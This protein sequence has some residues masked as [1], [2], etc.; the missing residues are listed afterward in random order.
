[1]FPLIVLVVGVLAAPGAIGRV[2]DG[3]LKIRLADYN[4]GQGYRQVASNSGIFD[5]GNANYESVSGAPSSGIVGMAATPDNEGYWL[6]SSS[7]GVYTGGDANFYGSVTSPSYPIVGMAATPDAGGYWLVSSNGT[8]YGRGDAYTYGSASG[9]TIVG[10]AATADGGGYWLVTP[11]GQVFEFGDAAPYGSVSGSLAA[12]IV[13]MAVTPDGAG[14]WLVGADGGVFTFG[15]AGFFGSPSATSLPNPIVGIA[16]SP[17]G[18]GYWLSGS[19]GGVLQYGDAQY[20]GGASSLVSSGVVG[21]VVPP[22]EHAVPPPAQVTFDSSGYV[23]DYGSGYTGNTGLTM[24]S[25]TSPSTTVTTAGCC[26]VAYVDTSGD[27]AIAGPNGRTPTWVWGSNPA[28]ARASPRS[29]PAATKWPSRPLALTTSTTTEPPTQGAP[30][31]RRW[32]AP[33]R[34]RPRHRLVA[35]K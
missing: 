13:G 24:L 28:R 15:D 21:I 31:C 12:P 33:V 11:A 23:Y 34:A 8:V 22:T 16:S 17:D 6:A 32:P 35:A 27:L 3:P 4:Y 9:V 10:I 30:G 25:G 14:Y 1:M 7:G 29:H 26:E 5:Y 19:D 20:L 2:P 18:Q